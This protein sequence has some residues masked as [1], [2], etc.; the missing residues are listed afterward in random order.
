[1]KGGKNVRKRKLNILQRTGI[2]LILAGCGLILFSI[3]PY[4]NNLITNMDLLVRV[5]QAAILLAGGFGLYI[6][7]EKK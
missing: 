4:S 2:A 3:D 5:G 1:M 7:W 6:P